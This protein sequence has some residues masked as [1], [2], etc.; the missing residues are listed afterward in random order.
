MPNAAA[1]AG[2]GFEGWYSNANPEHN[3]LDVKES[4]TC[5]LADLDT[6]FIEVNNASMRHAKELEKEA[7]KSLRAQTNTAAQLAHYC[8]AADLAK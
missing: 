8:L 2:Q 7:S 3:G 6:L 5:R 1:A 4:K